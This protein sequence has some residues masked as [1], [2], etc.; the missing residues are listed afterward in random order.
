[1]Q[2]SVAGEKF[3]EDY[4]NANQER[5]RV[6]DEKRQFYM[7]LQEYKRNLSQKDLEQMEGRVTI[8]EITKNDLMNSYAMLVAQWRQRSSTGCFKFI[9]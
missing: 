3:Q 6:R 7:N 5:K 9:V 8:S 2:N 1:M 4:R